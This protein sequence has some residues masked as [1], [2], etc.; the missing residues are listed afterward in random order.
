[1]PSCAVRKLCCLLQVNRQWYFQH[2]RD[3]F[4]KTLK[5]EE[6]YLHQYQPFDEAQACLQTFLEDVY[7]AKTSSLIVGLRASR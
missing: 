6:V 5:W 3:H 1:M 2:P 7:N 4:I